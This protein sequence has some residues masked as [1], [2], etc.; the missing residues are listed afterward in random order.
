MKV[1]V[2]VV[3]AAAPYI[4]SA[5]NAVELELVSNSTATS[6]GL[7]GN[8]TL[9]A[10]PQVK[11]D[12]IDKL[13]REIN[14]TR[15]EELKEQ[16]EASKIKASIEQQ[17]AILHSSGMVRGHE[18]LPYGTPEWWFNFGLCILCL[19][20]A[21]TAAGLTMGLVGLDK[22]S[23][24]IVLATKLE[25]CD[26]PEERQE[27]LED[28]RYAERLKPVLSN[29][30]F[31]LVTLLLL[32]SLANEAL[33]IFLG[34]LVPSWMAILLS[35]CGVLMVGEILP[36]AVFTGPRQWEI[37]SYFVPLVR[38]LQ[39]LFS[40]IAWPMSKMLDIWLGHEDDQ[41]NKA[42]LTGM[43]RHLRGKHYLAGSSQ[44]ATGNA[45]SMRSFYSFFFVVRL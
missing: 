34:A 28:K 20:S 17:E 4:I 18:R 23:V 37:A 38:V 41:I 7:R 5:Q 36:S 3:L 14:K 45:Q 35:V 24:D 9:L 40:P 19:V 8:E 6:S 22:D 27:L 42:K 16:L 25:D 11:L 21:A 10:D 39:F 43:M 26:T 44:P 29:H 30:H 15:R 33:P 31:M 32:N 2:G 12:S 1:I 13:P